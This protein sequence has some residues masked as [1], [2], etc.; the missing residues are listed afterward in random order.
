[1][2]GISQGLWRARAKAGISRQECLS[3]TQPLWDGFLRGSQAA[4]S[5]AAHACV[6][7]RLLLSSVFAPSEEGTSE[8]V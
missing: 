5:T 4:Q 8:D 1:M 6:L 2:T 3:V 7:P